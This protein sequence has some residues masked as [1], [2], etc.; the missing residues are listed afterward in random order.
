MATY[1]EIRRRYKPAH[2][3][4]LLVAESPPPA[5]HIQSSRHFYRSEKVRVGD[6]L[7]ANT[8]RALYPEAARA[9]EPE[10]EAH[11][12]TW[13]RRFQHDGWYMIEALEASQPH[14]ATKLQ[15]QARIGE[16]LPQLMARVR[17]LAEPGTKL[18][19]IKSNVFEIA[20]APLRAAGFT[21]L[22]T[23]LVD[24][25]GRYNQAAYRQKLAALACA[26]S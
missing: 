20:A 15:R 3:R 25:P 6:R 10:L 4:V 24:Y 13:L 14:E 22:N 21:V 19:L 16:S 2:I 26:A 23:Q 8:M 11:K 7:F 12:E 18:I 17:S 5:A 9:T 1:D